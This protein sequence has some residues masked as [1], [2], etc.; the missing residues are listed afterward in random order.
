MAQV[1]GV[2]TVSASCLSSHRKA[3]PLA[4]HLSSL[5]ANNPNPVEVNWR[6]IPIT[7]TDMDCPFLRETLGSLSL[8]ADGAVSANYEK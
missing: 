6:N 4:R 5:N 7:L 2:P 3:L 1:A 8:S